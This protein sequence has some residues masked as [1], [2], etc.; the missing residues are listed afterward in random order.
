MIWN[1]IFNF[2]ISDLYFQIV[3]VWF[4]PGLLLIGICKIIEFLKERK[5]TKEF[6]RKCEK[7]GLPEDFEAPHYVW[8][9]IDHLMWLCDEYQL[10][11]LYEAQD[12]FEELYFPYFMSKRASNE[13][14]WLLQNPRTD[15]N[16]LALRAKR[17]GEAI[18][19]EN[20]L[21]DKPHEEV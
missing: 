8:N 16:E 10:N 13:E 19:R 4:I 20:D 21:E 6:S 9:H 11:S 17:H 5:D 1:K 14:M 2:F 3:T 12:K 18:E 7:Y 15:E